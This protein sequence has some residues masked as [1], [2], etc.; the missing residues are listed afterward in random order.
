MAEYA[1]DAAMMADMARGN[2]DAFDRL[3]DRYGN[4]VYAFAW[5]L[6]GDKAAADDVAQD[7]LLKIWLN[8]GKW[9]PSAKLTTWLYQITRHCYVD[10]CRRIKPTVSDDALAEMPSDEK[11][12]ED[13]LIQKDDSERVAKAIDALPDSQK[14]ALIL[15]YYQGLTSGEAAECLGTSRTAVESLLFRAR[16]TLK[17]KLV[18]D[19]GGK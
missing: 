7:A 2:A 1:D 18:A 14:E 11:S 16:Q 3:M 19:K 10:R 8:A 17:E 6:C 15:C 4:S 13:V 12:P 9:R 5:R